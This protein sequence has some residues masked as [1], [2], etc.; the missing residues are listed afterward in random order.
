[1]SDLA[2]VGLLDSDET[3]V[4]T[5]EGQRYTATFDT[6]AVITVAGLGTALTLSEARALV[7][8]SRTDGGG[9]SYWKVE[10]HGELVPLSRLREQWRELRTYSGWTPRAPR[11]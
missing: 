4:A 1:M 7:R 8:G 10:R 5:H 3:L 11:R 9:W 6:D 2:E